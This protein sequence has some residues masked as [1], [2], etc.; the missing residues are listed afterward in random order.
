M[1]VHHN[2][3]TDHDYRKYDLTSLLGKTQRWS[4]NPDLP[5][6]VEEEEA[7]PYWDI[8][9]SDKELHFKVPTRN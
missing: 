2:N 1:T 5:Q 8:S 7:T 4:L 3:R 9:G 6:A